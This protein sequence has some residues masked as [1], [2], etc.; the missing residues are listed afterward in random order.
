M[1]MFQDVIDYDA[2]IVFSA[3]IYAGEAPRISVIAKEA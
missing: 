1:S 2:D 3:N